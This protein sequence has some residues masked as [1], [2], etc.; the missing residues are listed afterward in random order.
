V[1]SSGLK[2][3]YFTDLHA[4]Y[5]TPE[6]RTDDFKVS[7]LQKLEEIGDI[8]RE[9]GVEL[10]LFGGDLFHTPDPARSV[11]HDVMH[12]LKSWHLQIIGVV[13][14]HD[15]FGYQMKTLKRT[16]LGIFQK[17]DVI[18]LVDMH[19]WMN[20]NGVMIYGTPHRY[21][22]L[23]DPHNFTVETKDCTGLFHIQLIHGDVVDKPAPWPHILPSQIKTG[24]DLALCGHVHSGW[25][26]TIPVDRQDGGMT[27]FVNPGSIGRLENTGH[28]R[29][30]QVCIIQV[31]PDGNFT[32]G[33]H[34]LQRP[35]PHPFKDKVP[36][37]EGST[38][39]DISKLFHL[40]ETTNVDIV[41]VK[42]QLPIVAKEAGYSE[43]V[44][45]KAFELLEEKA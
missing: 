14:S 19:Q 7:L 26:G 15:Y 21:D 34:K 17:A 5:D 35:A 41:D 10:V 13:G 36:E 24:V 6:G 32:L 22:L 38:L 33:F 44:V 29:M 8:W 40:I 3:G 42:R 25:V 43:R 1:K 27:V 20:V 9:A 4:R 30:P 2:I 37:P 16:A 31:A 11:E 28:Q 45:A 18:Q 23:D 39:P 12:I